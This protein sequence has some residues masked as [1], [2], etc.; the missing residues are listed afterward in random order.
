MLSPAGVISQWLR[1]RKNETNQII[2]LLLLLHFSRDRFGVRNYRSM[3]GRDVRIVRVSASKSTFYKVITVYIANR[4][5]YLEQHLRIQTRIRIFYQWNDSRRGKLNQVGN[6]VA[7]VFPFHVSVI[8][9]VSMWHKLKGQREFPLL[10]YGSIL[11]CAKHQ[12]LV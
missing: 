5:Y 1:T 10:S 6:W 12:L 8:D 7:I 2:R 11:R 3:Q 9:S 4:L